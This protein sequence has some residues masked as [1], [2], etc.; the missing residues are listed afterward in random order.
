M[1]G[2]R[3][4]IDRS[5]EL[6]PL[7]L[8]RRALPSGLAGAPVELDLGARVDRLGLGEERRG[9][10]GEPRHLGRPG[11]SHSRV[12]QIEQRRLERK[13]LQGGS[14]GRKPVGEPIAHRAELL[15]GSEARRADLL[16][17]LACVVTETAQAAGDPKPVVGD[18]PPAADIFDRDS[19]F[20]GGAFELL[21]HRSGGSVRV[22]CARELGV[23]V[24]PGRDRQAAK[25]LVLFAKQ[26]LCLTE[27]HLLLVVGGLLPRE[28]VAGRR[29]LGLVTRQRGTHFLGPFASSGDLVGGLHLGRREE[30]LVRL[31]QL[32]KL[33][34]HRGDRSLCLAQRGQGLLVLSGGGLLG[35]P[36]VAKLVRGGPEPGSALTQ[37]G[38]RVGGIGDG[39]VGDGLLVALQRLKPCP[40]VRDLIEALRGALEQVAVDLGQRIG[41]ELVQHLL[42]ERIR[43]LRPPQCALEADLLDQP[44]HARVAE[45]DLVEPLPVGARL[46]ECL[47]SEPGDELGELVTSERLLA[48]PDQL[49]IEPDTAVRHVEETGL[50]L[51]PFLV[52]VEAHA[53]RRVLGPGPRVVMAELEPRVADPVR[54][55]AVHEQVPLHLPCVL[56]ER[57]ELGGRHV[58]FEEEREEQLH[59]LRLAGPVR[60]A[61]EQAPISEFED[62]VAVLEDVDDPGARRTPAR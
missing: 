56:A 44:L 2:L 15:L 20:L 34:A 26:D 43:E 42:V 35:R 19:P 11:L 32:F 54:V 46:R 9:D 41:E 53:E 31:P 60:P 10:V 62:L 47:A 27:A 38:T 5:L 24:D 58:A 52:G 51:V 13:L 23:C 33:A 49:E 57:V 59:R 36:G 28:L 39:K 50:D 16:G 61:Q 3:D 12:E 1:R 8:E 45:H 22:A 17:L 37:L 21:D 29:Q 14:P 30:R 48:L 25:P 4:R 18:S 6:S 7:V 40:A 55:L